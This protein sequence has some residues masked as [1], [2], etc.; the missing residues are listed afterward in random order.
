MICV[1][2]LDY[3]E[4]TTKKCTTK[5]VVRSF[6]CFA[7][8]RSRRRSFRT[9]RFAVYPV[10]HANFASIF[11]KLPFRSFAFRVSQ[12]T[13]SLGHVPSFMITTFNPAFY[14]S[15]K[16][17]RWLFGPLSPGNEGPVVCTT[18]TGRIWA[19]LHD[20]LSG[21]LFFLSDPS[22]LYWL[23]MIRFNTYVY[24]LIWLHF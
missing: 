16:Y 24:E 19:S 6:I 17:N 11:R 22:Y 21:P 5:T 12:I 10:S 8:V 18:L 23:P 2:T 4:R 13:H 3:G 15:Y 7:A 9:L 1:S 14:H 20:P